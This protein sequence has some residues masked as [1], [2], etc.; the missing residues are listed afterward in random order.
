MTKNYERVILATS[1]NQAHEILINSSIEGNKIKEISNKVCN[2]KYCNWGKIFIEI[3]EEI[4]L[5]FKFINKQPNFS[6]FSKDNIDFCTWQT[7]GFNNIVTCF[8]GGSNYEFYLQN[9]IEFA[10]KIKVALCKVLEKNLKIK[11]DCD[12]HLKHYL[13]P[14]NPIDSFCSINPDIGDYNEIL[15]F[16]D[17]LHNIE[18]LDFVDHI[19]REDSGLLSH[20]FIDTAYIAA[21]KLIWGQT[22]NIKITRYW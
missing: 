6:I 8:F 9:K 11:I 22:S 1:P 4:L 18:G 17:H 21:Q 7:P 10:K 5:K 20:G 13:I 3:S 12:N 16:Q 14:K 19:S 2:F 15:K